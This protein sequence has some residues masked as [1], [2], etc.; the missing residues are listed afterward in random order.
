MARIAQKAPARRGK[1]GL[2]L[3]AFVVA[4]S[5]LRQ[6]WRLLSLIGISMVIAAILVCAVP[7]FSRLTITAGMRAALASEP[8]NSL[9]LASGYPTTVASALFRSAQNTIDGDVQSYV[10]QYISHTSAY[11]MQ[12]QGFPI[13]W[14]TNK[15]PVPANP[16]TQF[17][18]MDLIGT[19]PAV[20]TTHSKLMQ[21]RWPQTS[22][23]GANTVEIALTANAAKQMGLA[24]GQTIPISLTYH[25]DPGGSFK[26]TLTLSI[27]GIF[28]IPARL[29]T[30]WNANT[31][32][33]LPREGRGG[34]SYKAL[35]SPD[36][37]LA[38]IDALGLASSGGKQAGVILEG[39]TQFVTA[40]RLDATRL[41]A[42]NLDDLIN[43]LNQLQVA[44]TDDFAGAQYIIG[45]GIHGDAFNP[46]GALQ[47]FRDRMVVPQMP[48]TVFLVE[49]MALVLL[50]ISMMTDLLVEGQS[51]AIALL[52]SRG[53]R[54][55]HVF[56]A[57][58]LQCG[59]LGLAA[60]LLGPALALPA[61]YLLGRQTLGS[62]D[63]GALATL[64]RDPLSAAQSVSG[65]A[66]AM[67]VAAVLTMFGAVSIA[68]RA[69]ML[70]VRRESARSTRRPLWQ[71]LYLDAIF[72]FVALLGYGTSLY[73]TQSGLHDEQASI[74]L[75]PL[76]LI[77]P[78]LLLLASALLFLRGF[79]L[80]LRGAEWLATR[81]RGAPPLLALS[82]IARSPNRTI[83]MMLL[84]ALSLALLIFTQTF[85]ASQAR[86]N[87]DA[88][89]YQV[90][91]DFRGIPD[92]FLQPDAPPTRQWL[93]AE[94]HRYTA[95]PGV[96]SATLGMVTTLPQSTLD[97]DVSIQAV[98]AR[99]FASSAVWPAMPDRSST[100][101]SLATLMARLASMR[102]PDL[103]VTS[104]PAV[105]DAT[106]W[107]ALHLDRGNHSF[108]LV[109]SS[110][111]S[112]LA[113]GAEV[114]FVAIGVLP[115]IP[116]L[117]DRSGSGG[118]SGGYLSK[119][120]LVDYLT[121]AASYAKQTGAKP[122][123]PDTV[124]LRTRDDAASLA[125]VRAAL[126][127]KPLQV[128]SL[129]DRRAML[130]E[131]ARDPLYLDLVGVLNVCAALALLLA[132]AGDMLTSWIG[133]RQRVT[134]F[135]LLRALGGEPHQIAGVLLWEQGIIYTTALVLGLALGLLLALSV[136]PVLVYTGVV[137]KDSNYVLSNAEFFARQRVPPVSIVW[138]PTLAAI[139][140]GVVVLCAL[141]IALMT[142]TVSRPAIGRALRLN[143]D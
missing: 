30:F 78:V 2:L 70:S 112:I 138:P 29:D 140:I 110:G 137:V 8:D 39:L 94:T 45:T 80:L 97:E 87:I 120:I 100:Q 101:P 26:R 108:T 38:T 128:T 88:A 7:L 53:A 46:N 109:S 63:Y 96:T 114:S 74:I 90:G 132:L 25:Q 6:T 18:A 93:A 84:L 75:A 126:S 20:A 83:R 67:A 107:Q 11:Y 79:S 59:V 44:I 24:V 127:T 116:P 31:F 111:A 28:T 50:F 142:R 131:L 36:A 49:S 60:L 4:R 139:L 52:R 104:I 22:S 32:Q 43:Q 55:G 85:T 134:G 13:L 42:D 21:G 40:Y 58:A 16:R 51:D 23:A 129:L 119:G 130:A 81:G 72:A 66:L 141:A 117:A 136:V 33:P 113:G 143:E 57:L 56:G 17:D 10:G 62:N 35:V 37:L 122:P 41:S 102:T 118:T 125:H 92:T 47:R 54:R 91:T 61:A 95:I 105:V 106:L 34:Y 124:W 76:S 3:P 65:Y 86:R 15:A 9:L 98:D 133:A 27:V 77:A 103:A 73:L 123:H 115:H 5:Q 19:T 68:A 14:Q 64:L 135:A 12:M 48:V 99:T 89:A 82:Q 121:Y 69:D 1:A 71:R